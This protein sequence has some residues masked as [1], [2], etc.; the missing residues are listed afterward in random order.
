MLL[1]S[2]KIQFSVHGTTTTVKIRKQ[3]IAAKS[4]GVSLYH[5]KML[6]NRTKFLKNLKS[7]ALQFNELRT[8]VKLALKLLCRNQIDLSYG[9]G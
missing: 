1:E 5:V 2:H 3:V 7:D 4:E 6:G 9:G 8:L